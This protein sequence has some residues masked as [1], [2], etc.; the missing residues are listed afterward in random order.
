MVGALTL[1]LDYV[2]SDLITSGGYGGFLYAPD[3]YDGGSITINNCVF[4]TIESV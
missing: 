3:S 2:E 1:S 4:D